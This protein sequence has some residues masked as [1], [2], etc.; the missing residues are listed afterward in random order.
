MWDLE[1]SLMQLQR[2]KAKDEKQVKGKDGA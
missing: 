1:A 2:S